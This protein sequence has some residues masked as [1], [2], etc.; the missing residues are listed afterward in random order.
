MVSTPIGNLEDISMRAINILKNSDYILCEDTRVSKK[1]LKKYDINSKLISNHKFNEKKNINKILELL[2]SGS[3]I[4]LIS[5]A[6]TP[7]VSDPGNILV[8]A[9][10]ENNIKLI[11]IPGA[12]A[13][14]SAI[15]ICG[16]SEK[17]FFM[18][19]FQKKENY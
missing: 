15:S 13:V 5:D 9:C 1:L 18:D 4:S 16:F 10:I 14:L 3:I 12:S 11:P 6:G 19:F 2:K 8:N 7:S 17:F